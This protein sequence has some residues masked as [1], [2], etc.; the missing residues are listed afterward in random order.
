LKD[1]PKGLPRRFIIG[2]SGQ[3][4]DGAKTADYRHSLGGDDLGSNQL[5]KRQIKAH[6]MLKKEFL[7]RL[8]E[9][10]IWVFNG[11]GQTFNIQ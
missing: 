10:M 2:I 5:E 7:G 6:I 11:I 4:L 8:W 1:K 9:R 3:E